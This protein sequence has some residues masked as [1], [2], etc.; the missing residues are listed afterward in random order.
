M[1]LLN[2]V[3]NFVFQSGYRDDE[4]HL[5]SDE[6]EMEDYGRYERHDKY[7]RY[8][9]GHRDDAVTYINDRR[10][11]RESDRARTT[12]FRREENRGDTVEIA[13]RAAAP[14]PSE[15]DKV[16]TIPSATPTSLELDIIISEPLVFEDG[17]AVC[18]QLKKRKP[19]IVNMENVDVKEAQR[20]MDFLAGVVYCVSGD[21]QE[22]TSRIF[23]VTPEN[24]N[25]SDQAKQHLKDQGIFSSFK[26]AFGA[27]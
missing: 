2:S 4:D 5:Y 10:P 26:T 16:Y 19:V 3:R 24:V 7:D 21:I 25:V 27:R 14:K 1:G 12:N 9:R 23:I 13:N 11:A 18:D 8:P 6:M 22:I 20:I 15:R 17:L